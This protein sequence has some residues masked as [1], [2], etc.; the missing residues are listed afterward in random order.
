LLEQL[1]M[2]KQPARRES[3]FIREKDL[4]NHFENTDGDKKSDEKKEVT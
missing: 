2:P 4:E 3:M 1:E